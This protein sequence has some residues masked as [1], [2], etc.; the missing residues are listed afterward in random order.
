MNAEEAAQSKDL[1]QGECQMN[2]NTLI[3][4]YDSGA[5]HLFISFDCVNRL[6]LPIFELPYDLSICTPTG[7]PVRKTQVYMRCPF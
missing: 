1:I 7:K 5:T 6:K 3:V 2:G 4:L